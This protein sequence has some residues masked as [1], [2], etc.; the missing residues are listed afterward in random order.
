MSLN[1]LTIPAASRRLAVLGPRWTPLFCLALLTG[2]CALASFALACA[3][4][5]AAFAVVA[6][7]MLPLSSALVMMAAVW[8]IN[9]AIGF[10]ALNY[11]LDATTVLWGTVILA[12]ALA[13][14]SAAKFVLLLLS[15]S[16]NPVALGAALVGAYAAFEVVLV[17]ATPFLGGVGDFTA[18][19]V[20]HLGV[21]NVLWLI[22]LVAA[23]GIVQLVVRVGERRMSFR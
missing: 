3:T 14:A 16:A 5:F 11:P 8:F 22:G 19:I 6:V 10:G 23:C 2:A 15:R 21:L 7:A 13:A 20:G 4:P 12:A 9:Q 17:A 1:S 18:A